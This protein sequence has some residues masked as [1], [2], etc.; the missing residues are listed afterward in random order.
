MNEKVDGEIKGRERES[1]RGTWEVDTVK[2][3][4]E[5]DDSRWESHTCTNAWYTE[6]IGEFTFCHRMK[7]DRNVLC[8]TSLFFTVVIVVE[9]GAKRMEK[10]E[11]SYQESGGEKER[12]DF[13]LES[14]AKCLSLS[15]SSMTQL[16]PSW[17][18]GLMPSLVWSEWMV[19]LLMKAKSCPW[20]WWWVWLVACS[21]FAWFTCAI[22]TQSLVNPRASHCEWIKCKKWHNESQESGENE[23]IKWL[24]AMRM[25]GGGEEVRQGQEE[26]RERNWWWSSPLQEAKVTLVK[27]KKSCL[28]LLFKLLQV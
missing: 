16:R 15:L 7:G 5:W 18:P 9:K 23:W 13:S 26:S 22:F 10:G 11:T 28:S 6:G 24:E 19:L 3:H 14:A 21:R 1:T 4:F 2:S 27:E 12:V 25:G 8:S 17:W 20:W